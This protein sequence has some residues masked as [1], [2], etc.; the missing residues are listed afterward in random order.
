MGERSGGTRSSLAFFYIS[1][2]MC[3][4]V[5]LSSSFGPSSTVL[6]RTRISTRLSVVVL[7]QRGQWTRLPGVH[8]QDRT[9]H[10]QVGSFTLNSP[11]SGPCSGDSF[12]FLH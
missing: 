10:N 12:S 8:R 7:S 11:L 5:V 2:C 6:E 4:V 3:V 9:P 1:A